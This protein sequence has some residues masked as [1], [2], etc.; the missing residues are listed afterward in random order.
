MAKPADY[1]EKD[2]VKRTFRFAL[3]TIKIVGQLPKDSIGQVL[4][5]QLMRS[6]TSIGA[7]VREAQKTS[8][9]KAFIHKLNIA[10]DEAEET[11]YWLELIRQSHLLSEAEMRNILEE[12]REICKILTIIIKNLKK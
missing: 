7:N 5:R 1:N 11:E 8:T 9:R 12:C 6:G 4:S 2:I 10:L 3:L